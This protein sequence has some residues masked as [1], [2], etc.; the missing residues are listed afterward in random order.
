MTALTE[1]ERAE[2]QRLRSEHHEQQ[3]AVAQWRME[4]CEAECD[5]EEAARLL[6]QH[7]GLAARLR[8]LSQAASR[9]GGP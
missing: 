4:L 9:A 7:A 1:T 3:L 2:L 6:E 5:L 8:S